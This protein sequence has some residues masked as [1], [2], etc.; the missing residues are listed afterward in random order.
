MGDAIL[1]IGAGAAFAIGG[2][3]VALNV[4]AAADRLAAHHRRIRD[5]ASPEPRSTESE[6]TRG[7]RLLGLAAAAAGAASIA[8]AGSDVRDDPAA[9][10]C[11]Y[12][13]A[14]GR[15]LT[16]RV[17][18]GSVGEIVRR[19]TQIAAAGQGESPVRCSGGVPTVRNTDTIV[20]VLA[21]VA[22]VDVDLG[23][24]AFEPGAT[25]EDGGA[26][27]IEIELT[28]GLGSADVVGTAGDDEWRWVAAGAN[29][30]LNLNPRDAGDRDADVTVVATEDESGPLVADGGAGDDTIVGAPGARVR[31]VVV[32]FGDAGDDR[33][34]APVVEGESGA[35]LDGGPGDDTIDSRNA[36]TDTV[37]CGSGRDRATAD[38]RD[39]LRGCERVAAR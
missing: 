25:H 8:A 1:F 24:G 5:Q 18:D 19:G 31:G 2:I 15:V 35:E 10:R 36:A 17:G 4:F 3:A 7:M 23:G 27:E 20:I 12:A 6:T 9:V 21:G 14:P 26:S 32:A 33:L 37:A 34:S 13:G 28:P 39:R 38:P 22:F 29:P 30:G 11:S 16:V